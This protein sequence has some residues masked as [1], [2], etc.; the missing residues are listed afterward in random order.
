LG[1]RWMRMNGGKG[2][3]MRNLIVCTVH[4]IKSR[5]LRRADLVARMK[6]GRSVFEILTK[7]PSGRDI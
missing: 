3:T 4:L 5:R 2:S 1:P 7:K 6:E